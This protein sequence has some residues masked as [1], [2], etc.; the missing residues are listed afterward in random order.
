MSDRASF[1][2]HQPSPPARLA[3][4]LSPPPTGGRRPKGGDAQRSVYVC[5]WGKAAVFFSKKLRKKARDPKYK[6]SYIFRV[7]IVGFTKN[8]TIEQTWPSGE[9]LNKIYFQP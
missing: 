8:P 3:F 5:V 6:K 2:E 7:L 9:S 1:V 4:A